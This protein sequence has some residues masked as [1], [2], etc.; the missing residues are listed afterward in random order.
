MNR[1]GK[2]KRGEWMVQTK[3]DRSN[4][5]EDNPTI[6]KRKQYPTSILIYL[7]CSEKLHN[8]SSV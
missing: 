2:S 1:G 4:E 8:C 5:S 3:Y 6:S 7:I